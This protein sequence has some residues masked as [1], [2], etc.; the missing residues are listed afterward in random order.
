MKFKILI[1]ISLFLISCS[2]IEMKRSFF[3]NSIF[4]E[5]EFGESYESFE[6]GIIEII[7]W[8]SD[9]EEKYIIA[10]EKINNLFHEKGRKTL[11]RYIINLRESFHKEFEYYIYLKVYK[12]ALDG[13]YIKLIYDGDLRNN[14]RRISELI[15]EVRFIIE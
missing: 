2:G 15:K 3:T 1:L 6:D 9:K 5:V 14:Q 13:D 7:I 4:V 8:K 12:T 11:R 10:R